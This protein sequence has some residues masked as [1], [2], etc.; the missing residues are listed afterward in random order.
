MVNHPERFD[1]TKQEKSLKSLVELAKSTFELLENLLTWSGQQQGA[2]P[3]EPERIL[4]YPMID[5]IIHLVNPNLE[6]KEIQIYNSINSKSI[7]FADSNM[8]KTIFRNLIMNAIKY[9]PRGGEIIITSEI[10]NGFTEFAVKDS[11]I[12][13]PGSIVPKLFT[14]GEHITT[15]GTDNE[16]G[17]GLG[18][19]LCK[20]FVE[21]NNGKI[22]VESEPGIGSIFRFTL[23]LS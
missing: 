9:T 6:K 4:I 23:P 2:I 11:G 12:G 22:W 13:I 3:F 18:L 15:P 16:P 5:E 8:V 14:L 19:V 17:S 1:D 10:K 21:Q 7:V 20:D